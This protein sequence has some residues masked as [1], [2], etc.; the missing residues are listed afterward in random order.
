VKSSPPTASHFKDRAFKAAEWLLLRTSHRG[1]L[2]LRYRRHFG[3]WP[4]LRKPRRFTEH[5]L[6]YKLLTR[7][8]PRLPQLADKV[9]AK[10]HVAQLVGAQYLVPT[11]WHGTELPP[12]ADRT[13]RP[14]FVI[15]STH[16]SMQYL[17]V[18]AGEVPDWRLIEATTRQWL[19][20]P[21][22]FGERQLEWHYRHIRPRLI[23]EPM[24]GDGRTLPVD[25]KLGVFHGRVKVIQ[26]DEGRG[27]EQTR[28]LMSRGWELLPFSIRYPRGATKPPP[29]VG[30]DEMIRIAERLGSEFEYVRVDLYNIAGQ[31]YFGEMTFFPGAGLTYFDPPEGDYTMGEFWTRY[32]VPVNDGP[33]PS[34]VSVSASAG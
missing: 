3:R 31:I 13:W 28:W 1:Y 17:F 22:E 15:K 2:A 9:L 8:D 21:Y 27:G 23:V 24:L 20:A 34:L 25:Y 12:R 16:A 10:D 29:P 7:G 32:A 30:L 5:L 19:S 6:L 14:P 26:V 4:N 33:A 18:R 11:L